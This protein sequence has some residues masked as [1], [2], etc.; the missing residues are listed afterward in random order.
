[1]TPPV[2]VHIYTEVSALKKRALFP[3]TAAVVLA[4]AVPGM[5]AD[6]KVKV[7]PGVYDPDATGI[8]VAG[9]QDG[10]GLPDVGGSNHGLV[11]QKN[12]ATSTNAAA[13][14]DITGV[15]GLSADGF[16]FDV[17]GYCGAGSPRFNVVTSDDVNH[18]LGCSYGVTGPSP[19]AG[20]SHLEFDSAQAFPP[21]T[22]GSTIKSLE[23]IADEQGQSVVDNIEVA[24]NVIGKP[25]NN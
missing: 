14:A 8:V 22:A 15:E 12:G 11:L 13:G 2:Q 9:W 19:A 20:W 7:K 10:V 3:L 1:M 21:I 24:G 18:F 5:A 17:N 16:A 23:L 4:V 25:G 6:G